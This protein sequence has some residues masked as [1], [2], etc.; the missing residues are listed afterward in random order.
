MAKM[1][2]VSPSESH[3]ILRVQT[4]LYHTE[5]AQ[6]WRLLAGIRAAARYAVRSDLVDAVEWAIGDSSPEAIIGDE[7]VREMIEQSSGAL[8]D[9]TYEFFEANLGS[10]GGQNRLARGA[11]DL[12]LV[13]NPDTYPAPTAFAELIRA[14]ADVRVAIAEA[15]QIPL[16]HPREYDAKTGETSWASGSC[17]LARADVF[18]EL[19]GF[20]SEN[21]L[22]HCDDVD[23]SWR[24]R[25][26]GHKVVTAPH[27]T[28]FHDKRPR[29]DDGWPA[30]EPEVFHAALGRM[31]L[32]CKWDRADILEETV[33]FIE[34]AGSEVQRAALEEFRARAAQG[35]LPAR[36]P[37]ADTVATFIGG[38]YAQHRF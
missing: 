5:L 26:A 25:L 4:V 11:G 38:E 14:L 21:F 34:A 20:D 1:P 23:L 10:S 7:D 19:G 3:R 33:S 9:V 2:L 17:M 16:E 32:A 6:L 37:K 8:S 12:L 28:I 30:P 18:A 31:M 24:A 36:L 22:L 27:A 35:R 29:M 15:R 13:L